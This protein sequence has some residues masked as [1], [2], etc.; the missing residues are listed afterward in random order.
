MRNFFVFFGCCAIASSLGAAQQ[1]VNLTVAHKLV[2]FTQKTREAIAV[3]DQIPGPILRFK[4]GDTVTINMH[5]EL[6]DATSIHW[7]GIMV[8]WQMDGVEGVSQEATQPGKSFKYEFS[9]QQSGTY[10]YHSHTGLQPQE[11]LYGAFIIDPINEPGYKYTKD[12]VVVLSDWSNTDANQIYGNLQTNG[13]YYMSPYAVGDYSDVA[14]DALLLNGQT[15]SK[16]W[17]QRVTVGDIVR[18]RFIGAGA[19]TIFRVK[20]PNQVMQTVHVQGND[21]TPYTC[22]DFILAP[23]ETHD[24]LVKIQK[25]QP[26]IIYAEAIDKT[27]FVYGALQTSA[28]Q[29]IDF[30]NIKPF[31]NP[32]VRLVQ[33][34]Y[35]NDV[36]A[37]A[38]NDPN[39]PIFKNIKMELTGSMHP[40]LWSINGVSGYMT[41]PII[42]E[43]GKRYRITFTNKTTM[44]HP[45][46][47]HGHWM[48]L[49]KG[50]GAHDPLLHTIL[51]APNTTVT[52][53]LDADASGQWIFHCHMLYHMQAG[54][55]G[56]LQYSTLPKVFAGK[57]QPQDEIKQTSF[58]NRPIVRVDEVM[59]IV[60]VLVEHPGAM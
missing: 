39:I 17:T 44:P 1:T 47:V 40:Y 34:K 52:A 21:V 11:G 37:V 13:H 9:L 35:K 5:N 41:P 33:N 6:R 28:T 58:I 19:S 45:M 46:H 31:P 10:W 22:D 12:F 59:P 36:G 3:N 53:D 57:M 15:K 30:K 26:Y 51:V 20:I 4:Q 38:T 27:G 48:I 60:P 16:P 29:K 24:V 14:Y 25:N 50:A 42:I 32:D 23:G 55:F 2:D 49:R 43:E 18:L 7:H 56:V 8:P 54:M